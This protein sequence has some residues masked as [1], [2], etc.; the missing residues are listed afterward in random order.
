MYLVHAHVRSREHEVLTDTIAALVVACALPSD[1]IEHI[2]AHLLSDGSVTLGLFVLAAC[3]EDAESA[4][5][6][7]CERAFSAYPELRGCVLVSCGSP[8][9]PVFIEWLMDGLCQGRMRT[10]TIPSVPPVGLPDSEYRRT[11]NALPESVTLFRKVAIGRD[12]SWRR[13]Y[14]STQPSPGRNRVM[15]ISRNI[16]AAVALVILAAFLTITGMHSV[17]SRIDAGH[18]AASSSSSSPD[19]LTWGG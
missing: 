13:L 16:S 4:A 10:A 6:R 12:N 5:R 2:A 15:T 19:D 1:R 9:V 7:T 11:R 18:L 3:L 14:C 8:L 17:G